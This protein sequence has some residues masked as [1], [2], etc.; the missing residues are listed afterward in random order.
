MS[1]RTRLNSVSARLLLGLALPLMLDAAVLAA[2]LLMLYLGQAE[3]ARAGWRSA[4]I[5]GGAFGLTALLTLLLALQ[6][7]RGI[8]RPLRQLIDAGRALMAGRY[9]SVAPRGPTEVEQ[10]IVHFNHLALTLAQRV[11]SL[12]VQEERYRTYIGAV[13]HLLWTAD[14]SGAAAD[15]LPGWRAFT[16]QSAEAVRGL[17]WLDAVHAEDREAV[18]RA[19]RAAVAAQGL[20]EAEFRLRGADGSYRCFACR[21]V[22]VPTPEGAVREW[23]GTCT[24]VTER[25]QDAELRRAKEAAEA[26]SRAKSEFL[27]RMSHELRTPLNAVIGMSR[28]LETQRFGPLTDK[29]AEY[30]QDITLA[31]EHLLAL[32]NDILD[33]AKVQAGKMDVQA[34][35]MP[36]S[37]AVAGVLSTLGPLAESK[38]VALRF[39]PPPDG[40]LHTDPTRFR[41]VLYN[42][43]SNAVKY[44]PGPGKVTVCCQWLERAERGAAP[45]CT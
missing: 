5:I 6:T 21:G 17:G 38:G 10:L 43:L 32:I 39:E 11:D 41:Q 26:A 25:R 2:L 19:W 45:A 16:G 23:I 33:L 34:E 30:V 40:A 24:D 3:G 42:L 28:M 13:A 35:A 44:T 29:Q 1:V 18:E 36:L 14:A 7:G 37:A 22:P 12:Q 4:A 8:A 20:F 9:R 27:T 15:D 31:G